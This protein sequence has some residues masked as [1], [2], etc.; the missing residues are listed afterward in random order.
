MPSA[1]GF[2]ATVATMPSDAHS[3][4]VRLFSVATD[5]RLSAELRVSALDAVIPFVADIRLAPPSRAEEWRTQA[6][7][8]RLDAR[9]AERPLIHPA[10]CA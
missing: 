8:A 3:L 1:L 9:L 6:A 7:L 5:S 2:T 4:V 10:R